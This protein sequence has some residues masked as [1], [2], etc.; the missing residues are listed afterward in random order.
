[1]PKFPK[2]IIFRILVFSCHKMTLITIITRMPWQAEPERY[3]GVVVAS[4]SSFLITRWAPIQSNIMEGGVTISI[5][6]IT[7]MEVPLPCGRQQCL[8]Y[9]VNSAAPPKWARG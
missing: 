9:E 7:S 4:S 2:P 5:F 1:M 6:L 3:G 8:V